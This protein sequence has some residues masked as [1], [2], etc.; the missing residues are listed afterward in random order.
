MFP[1]LIYHGLK[2]KDNKSY[3]YFL[4]CTINKQI[5]LEACYFFFYRP[6]FLWDIWNLQN[7]FFKYLL[8]TRMNGSIN[9][10]LEES[11]HWVW[12]PGR[13]R[14]EVKKAAQPKGALLSVITAHSSRQLGPE[15]TLTW[16]SRDWVLICG[17]SCPLLVFTWSWRSCTHSSFYALQFNDLWS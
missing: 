15:W 2:M 7:Q 9:D 13:D 3:Y 8:F 5:L 1:K 4:K 10:L 17:Q 14:D 12:E 6:L 11:S 16:G